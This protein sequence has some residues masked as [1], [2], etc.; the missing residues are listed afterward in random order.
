MKYIN[1]SFVLLLLLIGFTAFSQENS[2]IEIP[3]NFRNTKATDTTNI[4]DIKWKT[5]FL[6]TDL[7][8]LI[9]VALAK[10]NEL[11]IAEK[12]ITIAN[13]QYKQSK[14]GNVP[15]INAYANATTTRLS[16]NSL[17]GLSTNQF[18]GK[19][20]IEDFSAGLNLSW[21]ADIWGKIKIRNKVH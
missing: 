21:E 20:H 1:K 18:L 9:D 10:N 5:F 14:W 3:N 6:E 17:N 12:N 7:V 11:Q 8:Q 16:E 19:N 15:Q 2:K 13:L 4:A